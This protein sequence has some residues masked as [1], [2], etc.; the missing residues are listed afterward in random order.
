MTDLTTRVTVLET[1]VKALEK[2]TGAL[3]T[4]VLALAIEAEPTSSNK[5]ILQLVSRG[6]TGRGVQPRRRGASRKRPRIHETVEEIL[7]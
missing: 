3:Q 6:R 1:Q 2:Y 7:T 5:R 4:I